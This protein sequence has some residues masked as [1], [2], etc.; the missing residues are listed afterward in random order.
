MWLQSA[1]ILTANL[2]RGPKISP[3]IFIGAFLGNISAYFTGESTRIIILDFFSAACNGAG[4]V[5][6]CLVSSYLIKK[7]TN[8]AIP[9]F[10]TQDVFIFLLGAIVAGGISAL[11]GVP[12]LWLTGRLDGNGLML[13]FSTWF[14]GDTVSIMVFAPMLLVL[15]KETKN[16]QKQ[17]KSNILFSISVFFLLGVVSIAM[18]NEPIEIAL[19]LLAPV[20]I[21]VILNINERVSYF[22]LSGLCVIAIIKAMTGN[23]AIPI[24]GILELQV[25]LAIIA[26][27]I[28]FTQGLVIER[29]RATEALSK[30]QG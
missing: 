27:T 11:L 6:G 8:T 24:D 21:L 2:F 13:A 28:L 10:N 19:L 3:G 17:N 26:M 1:L 29:S 20:L 7:R 16:I 4:D 15:T 30:I 12:P 14:I 25:F 18:A 22:F 9:L 5:I 23:P